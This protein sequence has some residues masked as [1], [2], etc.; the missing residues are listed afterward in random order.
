MHEGADV[1]ADLGPQ[2]FVVRFE[3][4]PMQTPKQ[5][6]LDE[7]RRAPHGEVVPFG[8]LCIRT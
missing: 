2:R 8:S 4:N 6:F 3:H 7:Q 5:T 1:E